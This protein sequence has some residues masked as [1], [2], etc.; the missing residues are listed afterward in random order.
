[1]KTT[2][3][4]F[5]LFCFYFSFLASEEKKNIATL[6]EYIDDLPAS[7]ENLLVV[8]D[9]LNWLLRI[10]DNPEV[11]KLCK[12]ENL[13]KSFSSAPWLNLK[14]W[15][16]SLQQ[17]A[18]WIPEQSVIG[19]D[20]KYLHNFDAVVKTFLYGMYHKAGQKVDQEMYK[21]DLQRIS[22]KLIQSIQRI[23]IPDMHIWARFRSPMSSQVAFSLAQISLAAFKGT[24]THALPLEMSENKIELKMN[25]QNYLT[26][27]GIRAALNSLELKG[28]SEKDIKNIVNYFHGLSFRLSLI[29]KQSVL[30]LKLTPDIEDHDVATLGHSPFP[31]MGRSEEQF[32]I[33]SSQWNMEKLLQYTVEWQQIV[34]NYKDS[35]FYKKAIE[36]DSELELVMN[37]FLNL[38]DK[39]ETMGAKGKVHYWHDKQTHWLGEIEGFPQTPHLSSYNWPMSQLN[40]LHSWVIDSS[41]DL[42][43]QAKITFQDLDTE[44]LKFQQDPQV[45]NNPEFMEFLD[46]YQKH[47]TRFFNYFLHQTPDLFHTGYY[48]GFYKAKNPSSIHTYNKK[49][50]KVE[51]TLNLPNTLFAFKAKDDLKTRDFI[52]DM[53]KK[54]EKVAWQYFL[55]KDHGPVLFEKSRI[56][57]HS[58]IQLRLDRLVSMITKGDGEFNISGDFDAHIYV[59]KGHLV[60]STSKS[61]TQQFL[62]LETNELA[63]EISDNSITQSKLQPGA[64]SEYIKCFSDLMQ[65]INQTDYQ[66]ESKWFSQMLHLIKTIEFNIDQNKSGYVRTYEGQISYP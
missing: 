24:S 57:K 9:P 7:V 47:L 20:E 58:I 33:L 54:L 1:M 59:H 18:T 60:L 51:L 31:D 3:F 15:T 56:L 34:L 8:H 5:S 50:K 43:K 12:E 29:K 36:I 41:V 55:K 2:F 25:L 6:P 37:A 16:K 40:P 63:F 26:E 66:E 17:Q 32:D 23:K 49:E 44:V 21:K 14:L 52:Q 62:N 27:K 64:F 45:K 39:I 10:L 19:L 65:K 28:L 38:S 61:L 48:L 46:F 13:P 53:T 11:I 30:W 4:T 22:K 42:V 35:I